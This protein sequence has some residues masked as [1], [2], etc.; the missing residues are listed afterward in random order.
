MDVTAWLRSLNLERY[1]QA[2]RENEISESVLL[3]LTTEDLKELGVIAVGHRGILLDA[4]ANL[5]GETSATHDEASRATE[6]PDRAHN[7]PADAERRQLTVMFCDLVGSTALSNRLDPEDLRS[8]IGAYHKSVAET[9]TR[10]R[11]RGR[12]HG[13]RGA[14]LFRLSL[15][16]RA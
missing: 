12:V 1:E 4:I 3:K 13:R 5:R 10:R 11:L 6:K 16:T 14:H 15:C 7:T 8:V 9:V 2:F